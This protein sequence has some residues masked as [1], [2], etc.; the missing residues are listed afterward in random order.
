[1][2]D[3]GSEVERTF[4]SRHNFSIPCADTQALASFR[5]RDFV[6]ALLSASET[7]KQLLPAMCSL[8]DVFNK[9]YPLFLLSAS[10]LQDSKKQTDLFW[11]CSC[12]SG[13]MGG[14]TQPKWDPQLLPR[15]APPH[16]ERNKRNR[17]ADC[18]AATSPPNVCSSLCPSVVCCSYSQGHFS[19]CSQAEPVG[20]EL[21]MR[22]REQSGRCRWT[23][24]SQTP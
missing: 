9:Q 15:L 16:I 11:I 5:P 1:M 23:N 10:I 8:E 4:C 19:H 12:C 6:S 17:E 21:P 20:N 13:I 24:H 14:V 18:P 3:C 22:W 2:L 7:R